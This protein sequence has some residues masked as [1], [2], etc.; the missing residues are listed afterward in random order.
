LQNELCVFLNEVHSLCT[1]SNISYHLSKVVFFIPFVHFGFTYICNIT[2]F[3]RYVTLSNSSKI[4]CMQKRAKVFT[5]M[6]SHFVR[7]HENF[8]SCNLTTKDVQSMD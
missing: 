6:D 5:T 2:K 3:I 1:N 7:L 8:S 4:C